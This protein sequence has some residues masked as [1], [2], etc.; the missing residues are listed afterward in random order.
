MTPFE[1]AATLARDAPPRTCAHCGTRLNERETGVCADCDET[2][3]HRAP[4]P[5]WICERC[6]NP[7]SDGAPLCSPCDDAEFWA[8]KAAAEDREGN[9]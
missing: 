9:G 8:A 6:G 7:D 3:K 1:S 2:P 5:A 4:E